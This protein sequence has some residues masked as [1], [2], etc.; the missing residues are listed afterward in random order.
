MSFNGYY[1]IIVSLFD[2]I[3]L[4]EFIWILKKLFY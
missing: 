4:K 3:Y 1:K 2:N